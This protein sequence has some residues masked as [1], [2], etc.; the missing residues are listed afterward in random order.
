MDEAPEI[1]NL[2]QRNLEATLRWQV[3]SSSKVAIANRSTWPAAGQLEHLLSPAERD[4]AVNLTEP[5]ERRH[6]ASRRAFQRLFVAAVAEWKGS[7]DQLPLTHARDQRPVCPLLPGICL[8]FSTAG[9]TAM[10]AASRQP[11]MGVDIERLRIIPNALQLA[12]RFF[13]SN[14]LA[15][16]QS[17]PGNERSTAF[18]RLWSAKEA[19]LKALGKGIV[20]GPDKFQFALQGN[21]IEL[22]GCADEGPPSAWRISLLEA[23]SG[24][25]AVLAERLVHP[26]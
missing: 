19:C 14:E 20:H 3:S 15:G 25:I 17:T 22:T 7:M 24:Y 6:Y 13:H 18:I 23:P 16:L 4:F 21:D 26:L 11:L 2:S 12:E 5:A 10:A 9:D 8:S 1:E